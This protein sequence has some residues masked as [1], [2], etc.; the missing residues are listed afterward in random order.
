MRGESSSA[1]LVSQGEWRSVEHPTSGRVWLVVD[2]PTYLVFEDLATDNGPD[3][4]VWVS[5]EPASESDQIE[6]HG[7]DIGLVK[8]NLGTQVYTVPASIDPANLKSAVLWCNRFSVAFG[9]ADLA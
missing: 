9:V 7:V 5:G 1:R 6:S 2:G 3:V 4:H 8:G